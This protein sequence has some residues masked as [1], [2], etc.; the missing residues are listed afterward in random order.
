MVALH[1]RRLTARDIWPENIWDWDQESAKQDEIAAEIAEE[2]LTGSEATFALSNRMM[3]HRARYPSFK[4]QQAVMKRIYPRRPLCGLS[5]TPEETDWLIERLTGVNDPLGVDVL[6][7]LTSA[8][9]RT[10]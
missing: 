1:N 7:K 6:A 3:A 9:A 8:R 5:L 10:A 2:G 4:D